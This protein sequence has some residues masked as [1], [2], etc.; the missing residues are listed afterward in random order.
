MSDFL[1]DAGKK[2]IN[3]LRQQL[4]AE[5]HYEVKSPTKGWHKCACGWFGKESKWMVHVDAARRIGG[6]VG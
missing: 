1:R 2:I 3:T 6:W 5:G 4:G